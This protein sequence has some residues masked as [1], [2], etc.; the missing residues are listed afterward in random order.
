MSIHMNK[1]LHEVIVTPP[2]KVCHLIK[3]CF[4]GVIPL[5]ATFLLLICSDSNCSRLQPAVSMYSKLELPTHLLPLCTFSLVCDNTVRKCQE[6][7]RFA[8]SKE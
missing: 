4:S 7:S 5:V 1:F 2:L 6:G 8:L 3:N